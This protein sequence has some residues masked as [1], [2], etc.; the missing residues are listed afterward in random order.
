MGQPRPLLFIFVLFKH[1]FYRKKLW[2]QPKSKSDHRIR[3]LAHW[4]LDHHYGS[5]IKDSKWKLEPMSWTSC[6][7]IY[8]RYIKK[9]LWLNASYQVTVLT[10]KNALF[11]LVML[12]FVC[13]N[14]SWIAS[15]VLN[16]IFYNVFCWFTHLKPFIISFSFQCHW[17]Y[18]QFSSLPAGIW[19]RPRVL[20]PKQAIDLLFPPYRVKFMKNNYYSR[21]V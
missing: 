7:I 8:F 5:T 16:N 9:V 17:R 3:R 13:G 18:L 10:S 1:K 12:K 4:P 6:I 14:N 20:C 19:T 21:A 15:E 11:L 2:R